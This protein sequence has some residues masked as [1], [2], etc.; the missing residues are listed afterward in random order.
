V[1]LLLEVTSAT[2]MM[3][4]IVVI[5]MPIRISS[6]S[7]HLKREILSADRAFMWLAFLQPKPHDIMLVL[8][9]TTGTTNNPFVVV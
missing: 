1:F 9:F 6:F 3:V 7:Y 5:V 2:L 8:S 4:V